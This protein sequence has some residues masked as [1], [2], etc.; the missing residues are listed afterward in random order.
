[1]AVGKKKP[2]KWQDQHEWPYTFE[3]FGK[4]GQPSPWNGQK[5]FFKLD[6]TDRIDPSTQVWI[7]LYTG[8]EMACF[9]DGPRKNERLA[10]QLRDYREQLH[11]AEEAKKR[12]PKKVPVP[13]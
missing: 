5:F 13:I 2:W 9:Y 3:S 6:R 8:L 10:N 1:M 7:K 11:E 12:A 4:W